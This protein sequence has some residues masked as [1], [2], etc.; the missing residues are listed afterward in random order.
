MIKSSLERD[1]LKNQSRFTNTT[2]A[3][4]R[5]LDISR[6]HT[7]KDFM[8]TEL[9]SKITKMANEAKR[10]INDKSFFQRFL[11]YPP[12]KLVGAKADDMILFKE[13]NRYFTS[14]GMQGLSL[15]LYVFEILVFLSC[16]LIWRRNMFSLFISFL[17][18]FLLRWVA[19]LV[20]E[21]NV[22]RKVVVDKKFF[23]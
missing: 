10:Y 11:K 20:L 16:N 8:N 14:V 13:P 19:K 17:F 4:P 23:I 12:V 18:D 9:I 7:L 6:V 1:Q 3:L 15:E 21:L 5:S 22:A 2:R